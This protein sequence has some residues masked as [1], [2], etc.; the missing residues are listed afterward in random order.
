MGGNFA[1]MGNQYRINVGGEDFYIDLLLYHRRLISNN[2]FITRK[3]EKSITFS[4]G[5]REEIKEFI[6]KLG[7]LRGLII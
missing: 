5:N 2:W 3:D 7:E 1:F 6:K 4:R